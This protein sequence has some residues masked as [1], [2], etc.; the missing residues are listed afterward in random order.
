MRH[1]GTLRVG[2]AQSL[3]AVRHSKYFFELF[4]DRNEPAKELLAVIRN[5][6]EKDDASFD[7]LIRH[8]EPHTLK[9]LSFALFDSLAYKLVLLSAH[10]GVHELNEYDDE[11]VVN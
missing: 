8:L 7:R 4:V 1:D 6:L 11:D 9:L 10:N 2:L 5:T 3:A